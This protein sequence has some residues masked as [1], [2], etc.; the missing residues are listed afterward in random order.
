MMALSLVQLP[1]RAA[2]F[3]SALALGLVIL[4]CQRPPWW[5]DNERSTEPAT[6]PRTDGWKLRQYD[7]SGVAAGKA[8]H[9]PHPQYEPTA[10]LSPPSRGPALEDLVVDNSTLQLNATSVQFLL[11]F[12]IV[13]FPKTATSAIL[14]WVALH[15]QVSAHTHELHHLQHGL[16]GDFV[17]ELYRLPAT[18]TA[19]SSSIAKR[20]YKAPRDVTSPKALE[21]LARHWPDARLVVGLRHPV[22]WFESFY[23]FRVRKGRIMA[24]PTSSVFLESLCPPALTHGVCVRESHFHRFLAQ[25]GKTPLQTPDERELLG[26]QS[27]YPVNV[28]TTRQPNPVF[29]YELSQLHGPSA[30]PDRFRLD[31]SN[32]LQLDPALEP[33]PVATAHSLYLPNRTKAMDLCHTSLRSLRA[34][35]MEG[36]R[37]ASR[38]IRHYL[39]SSPDV[40][41]SSPN[42]FRAALLSWDVDPCDVA[43]AAAGH[44]TMPVPSPEAHGQANVRS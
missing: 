35:L 11:D 44:L 30:D 22:Q 25:L 4:M 34:E 15:P 20:G 1:R 40:I 43:A 14:E 5:A 12:A 8:S 32:Y 29:L 42:Q 24:D 13:G 7:V 36:A 6:L 39:L 28:T 19:A 33:L 37:N 21:L 23:N 2:G 27:S 31:L 3:L 18:A 38:W 9:P 26:L 41:V 17:T 10:P 16:I